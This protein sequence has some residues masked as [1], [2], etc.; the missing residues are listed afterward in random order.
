MILDCRSQVFN[1]IISK[2]LHRDEG[3]LEKGLICCRR[4]LEV[5][6]DNSVPIPFFPTRTVHEHYFINNICELSYIRKKHRVHHLVPNAFVSPEAINALSGETKTSS[7][8]KTKS[9][10]APGNGGV[11]PEVFECG[12]QRL[13]PN[14][15]FGLALQS[16]TRAVSVFMYLPTRR[17]LQLRREKLILLYSNIRNRP[18]QPPPSPTTQPAYRCRVR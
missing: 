9:G 5:T 3:E 13:A 8:A 17:F 4:Q 11:V 15:S 1:S 7:A 16:V 2:T 18:P 6:I 12:D 10:S 14:A